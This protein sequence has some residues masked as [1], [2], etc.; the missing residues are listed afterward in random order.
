LR[1]ANGDHWN[2]FADKVALAVSELMRLLLNEAHQG[3]EEAWDIDDRRQ[4]LRRD[5]PG[6]L[7]QQP[8]R[9]D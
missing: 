6:A 8:F 9:R 4:R 1:A 7:H 3:W 5:V 2:L